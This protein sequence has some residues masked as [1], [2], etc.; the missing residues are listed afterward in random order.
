MRLPIYGK[1]L[2]VAIERIAEAALAGEGLLLRS[3]TQD[4]LRQQ[5][6]L[7][8]CPKPQTNDARVLVTAAA[9]LELFA[10]RAHQPAPAWTGEVGA[11]AEPVHLLKAAATMKRLRV[12]C[13][14]EAPLPL[15]QR[16]LYAPPNYLEFV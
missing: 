5:T 4:F 16:G 15:R 8:A 1:P 14:T 7:N 6:D 9:L 3:L 11:L 10:S 12:L 2:M 13:E